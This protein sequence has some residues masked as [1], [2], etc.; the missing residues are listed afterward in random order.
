[1]W[2]ELPLHFNELLQGLILQYLCI[3]RKTYRTNYDN[4]TMDTSHYGGKYDLKPCNS[5]IDTS[6]TGAKYDLGVAEHNDGNT[7]KEEEKTQQR[8]DGDG[9]V[10]GQ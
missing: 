1:M 2:D 8:G 4:D 6:R 7:G 10:K 5:D 3:I 9:P